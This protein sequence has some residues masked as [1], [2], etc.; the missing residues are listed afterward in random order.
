MNRIVMTQIEHRSRRYTAYILLNERREFLDLQVFVPEEQTLLDHIYVGYVEKVVESIHAAFVR[1]QN[2]TKC[3]LPLEDLKSPLYAKKQS[4][5]KA[6]CEGDEL[7]VQVVK[8]AV[9]TKDPVVSTKLIIHGMYCVLTTDNTSI[10][11]SKKIASEQAKGLIHFAS[12][13]CE[14]H[15]KA[16]YGLVIRTNAKEQEEEVLQEDICEVIRQFEQIKATGVHQRQGE[17]VYRNMP[18]YIARLKGQNFSEIDEI[19]TDIPELYQE[20]VRYLP[21]LS[22][23]GLLRMYQDNAISLSTLYNIR[24]NMDKLLSSRVWLDSGANIIIESLE[25]LTVIDVNSGKNISRKDE[26]LFSVNLEA[27]REIARQLR[28]RNISGMII[29]DFINMKSKQQQQE[30]IQCLKA[31]L[32]KDVVQASFVDITKLGLVEITRKKVYRSLREIMGT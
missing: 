31:E 8:E 18:G 5:R 20:I 11:V 26:A 10:A 32:K 24:G 13:L 9:K 7:L 4:K 25:T 29:I 30:L 27:A 21:K 1:I 3:Y 6:L 28:L 14:G 12:E 22:E 17:L 16:G 2:G 15:E 23:N 19:V